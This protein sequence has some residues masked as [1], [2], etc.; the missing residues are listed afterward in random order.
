VEVLKQPVVVQSVVQRLLATFARRRPNR[1]VNVSID[2]R[3]AVVSAEP[4]YLDQTLYNLLSNADK[5]SPPERPIE[6]RVSVEGGN[7][8][9]RVLDE[10]PGIPDEEMDRVFQ[11]FYRSKSNP[12]GTPGKGVG[13]AVCK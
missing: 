5:Y 9:F 11:S 1:Q 6:I 13:L 3:A 8:C 4:T 2:E 7:S 12:K 10:G